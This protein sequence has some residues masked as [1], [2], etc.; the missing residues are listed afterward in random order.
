M[1]PGNEKYKE[2]ISFLALDSLQDI[3]EERNQGNGG[4]K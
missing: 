4:N 2:N 1:D 3:Q